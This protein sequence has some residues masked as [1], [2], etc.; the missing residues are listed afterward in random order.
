MKISSE[1][2]IEENPLV[3]PLNFQAK[4]IES[5]QMDSIT[6]RFKDKATEADFEASSQLEAFTMSRYVLVLY[7]VTFLMLY[8]VSHIERMMG[9]HKLDALI[10]SSIYI[11]GVSCVNVVLLHTRIWRHWMF[12]V[13]VYNAIYVAISV[14]NKD[15]FE[16]FTLAVIFICLNRL[17]LF[18]ISTRNWILHAIFQI[19]VCNYLI[20]IILSRI[21]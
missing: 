13:V 11:V 4:M 16:G 1:S 18:T 19:S 17:F 9:S 20:D 12:H 8:I 6:L 14:L 5:G 2:L 15:F 10:N 7:A 21:M 3:S